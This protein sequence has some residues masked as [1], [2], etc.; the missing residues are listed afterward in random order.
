MVFTLVVEKRDD[1][2]WFRSKSGDRPPV[3]CPASEED[4][5]RHLGD[6]DLTQD[7]IQAVQAALREKGEAEAQ[8]IR[9]TVRQIDPDSPPRGRR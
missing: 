2:Y 3:H 8:V 7:E 5:I 9:A 1:G 6:Y 4:L